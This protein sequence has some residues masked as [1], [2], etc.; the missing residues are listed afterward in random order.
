MIDMKNVIEQKISNDEESICEKCSHRRVCRAIDNQPCF[1]CN[2]FEQEVVRCKDCEY[3]GRTSCPT[4]YEDRMTY[5]DCWALDGDNDFCSY[6]E[7]REGEC[8]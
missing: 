4:Y 2:Q 8:K 5:R 6:G 3:L 1:E 7:R